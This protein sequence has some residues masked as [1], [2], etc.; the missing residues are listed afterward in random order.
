V[1]LALL[2]AGLAAHGSALGHFDPPPQLPTPTLGYYEVTLDSIRVLPQGGLANGSPITL[3]IH[4]YAQAQTHTPGDDAIFVVTARVGDRVPIAQV[5]YF[6]VDCEPS[7]AL[8]LIVNVAR[9]PDKLPEPLSG[10][11]NTGGG[12]VTNEDPSRPH[13]RFPN[14]NGSEARIGGSIRAALAKMPQFPQYNTD[15]PFIID[16]NSGTNTFV[17]RNVAA[18]QKK[19]EFTTTMRYLDIP[20]GPGFSPG[21]RGPASI[22]SGYTQLERAD[23]KIR[24]LLYRTSSSKGVTR[25][26]ARVCPAG[27][28]RTHAPRYHRH[29]CG[30]AKRLKPKHPK[31]LDDFSCTADRGAV[32][33]TGGAEWAF[34]V[35]CS[36]PWGWVQIFGPAGS[37]VVDINPPAGW[38]PKPGDGPNSVIFTNS[39]LAPADS[40]QRFEVRWDRAVEPPFTVKTAVQPSG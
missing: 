2:C 34:T 16:P 27:P 14:A 38:Q 25:E 12:L 21:C 36:K 30:P 6:H 29:F 17:P 9:P 1:T 22:E 4:T 19:Y 28:G 39:A 24:A 8:D 32:A 26:E 7:E 5:I 31:P 3:F 35:G 37:T 10:L 33:G 13:T 11:L 18:D 23:S 40:P 15:K 20:A